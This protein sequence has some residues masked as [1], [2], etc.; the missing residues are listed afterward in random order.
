MVVIKEEPSWDRYGIVS[1]RVGLAG[2]EKAALIIETLLLFSFGHGF[3]RASSISLHQVV[4]R[5]KVLA[6]G[7]MAA[8]SDWSSFDAVERGVKVL[9]TDRRTRTSFERDLP[10][11]HSDRARDHYWVLGATRFD[12]V[13]VCSCCSHYGRSW[14]QASAAD[15]RRSFPSTPLLSNPRV[16]N[17]RWSMTGAMPLAIETSQADL[18]HRG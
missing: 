1:R 11:N 8:I 10:R 2:L 13:E 18:G 12:E 9:W 4:I 17:Q 6:L 15:G 16:D 7:M 3:G 14:T 5:A